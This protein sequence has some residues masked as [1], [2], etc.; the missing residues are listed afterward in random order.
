M[1]PHGNP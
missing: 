1:F